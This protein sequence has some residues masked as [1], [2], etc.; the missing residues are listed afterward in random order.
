[1]KKV[2]LALLASAIISGCSSA[3]IDTSKALVGETSKENI[4]ALYGDPSITV[5]A[6][7]VDSVMYSFDGHEIAF[8]FVDGIL[9]H[10]E[11][12][13]KENGEWVSYEVE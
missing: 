3:S 7:E 11:K 2:L 9:T 1:M 10:K 4:I 6:E 12:L 8:T 5:N 13:V